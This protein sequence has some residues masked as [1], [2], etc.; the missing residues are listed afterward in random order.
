MKKLILIIL[1]LWINIHFSSAQIDV[2]GDLDNEYFRLLALKNEQVTHLGY[3][4][5]IDPFVD[6]LTWSLWDH[7]S[8]GD[9]FK[10]GL[11]ILN[12][13]AKTHINSSYARGFNDGPVWKGK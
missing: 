3:W 8:K 12:P 5:T 9:Q 11:T 10:E 6:S 4:P 2:P 1:L 7:R 13:G